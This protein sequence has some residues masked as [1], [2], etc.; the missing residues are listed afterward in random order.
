MLLFCHALA[1]TARPQDTLRLIYHHLVEHT[2]KMRD[3]IDN[4]RETVV[5]V[6][7]IL[8]P[9][10]PL[11]TDVVPPPDAPPARP[12]ELQEQVAMAEEEDGL[13]AV[14]RGESFCN[15]MKVHLATHSATVPDSVLDG[16]LEWW[17]HA[18]SMMYIRVTQSKYGTPT[19]ANVCIVV[20][21][22]R[23]HYFVVAFCFRL[24]FL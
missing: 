20:V 22:S 12:E 14:S 3:D 19:L 15:K 13:D 2:G 7:E 10:L 9:L 11:M 16:T 23:S 24:P 5:A 1:V 21:T 6:T 17:E 8:Q 18:D 4:L